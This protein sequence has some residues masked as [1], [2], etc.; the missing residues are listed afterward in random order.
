MFSQ[1]A[2]VYSAMYIFDKSRPILDSTFIKLN[3]LYEGKR[4]DA[5]INIYVYRVNSKSIV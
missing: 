3:D 2:R 4:Y 1:T 5:L